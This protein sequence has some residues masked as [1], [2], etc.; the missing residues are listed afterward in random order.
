MFLEF[1][2]IALRA[3]LKVAAFTSFA[4]NTATASLP[5]KQASHLTTL[6]TLME[7][8]ALLALF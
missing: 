3:V 6:N 4:K 2:P 7:T 1:F 5:N 8:Q